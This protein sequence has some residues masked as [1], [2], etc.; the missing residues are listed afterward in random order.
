MFNEKC[1]DLNW[2]LTAKTISRFIRANIFE[3]F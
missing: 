3:V 1:T 2:L